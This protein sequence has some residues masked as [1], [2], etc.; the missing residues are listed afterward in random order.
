MKMKG[1]SG[2]VL[3]GMLVINVNLY[4]QDEAADDKRGTGKFKKVKQVIVSASRVEEDASMIA[5][6]IIVITEEDIKKM[7]AHS[8]I[9]VLRTVPDIY[10]AQNG[11][12]GGITTVYLRG[13]PTGQ[14]LVM[15]NGMKVFDP[16]SPDASFDAA[17]ITTD[18][19]ERIEILKGPQSVL[20][21]S[22]AIGG[23]INVITKR[24]KGRF[25][26]NA[27][28][29]MGS[30]RTRQGYIQGSG[31]L[32]AVDISASASGLTSDGMSR[33]QERE[34]EGERDFYKRYN[35]DTRIDWNILTT[36][37]FGA[38]CRYN[39]AWFKTDDGANQDDFNR[40]GDS[41]TITIMTYLD[42]VPVDWWKSTASFAMLRYRRRDQDATDDDDVEDS[43]SFFHGK[44]FKAGWQ[45]SFFIYDID[46][47]TAG[48]E[49][50]HERG[51]ADTNFGSP[52][53]NSK[54]TISVKHNDV[55]SVFINNVFHYWGFYF[56]SGVRIDDHNR[57]GTYNTQRFAGA[58]NFEWDQLDKLPIDW[59][60]FSWA[61]L[62]LKTKLRGAYASGFKSPSI[63]QL[64]SEYGK[65]DLLPE[66][67]WGW[68][69]G[70]EQNIVGNI[71]FGEITYFENNIKDLI[72]YDFGMNAYD[73][74]GSAEMSGYEISFHFI[75]VDWLA[76]KG[77]YSYYEKIR[78][79]VT[80]EWLL[81]RPK[82]KFHISVD[83]TIFKYD[84]YKEQPIW[85]RVN[86]DTIYVG[87]RYDKTGW[88]SRWELLQ[89]F[90]KFDLVCEVGVT[91][92]LSFYYKVQNLTDRFYEEVYG[93][94][95]PERNHTVGF[96]A[97]ISF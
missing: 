39:Y 30:W 95:T 67:S 84:F 94:S 92:F 49:F 48:F 88:P 55:K 9:D 80:K 38:E 37:S 21:G 69:V 19:I 16:M 93:Y 68:E 90:W 32:G 83:W 79:K 47:I 29:S 59:G 91:E 97:S 63:Y 22:N 44:D 71:L 17:H 76:V 53:W 15:V 42:A 64:Y 56:T 52:W 23:V 89:S 81:R 34:N 77:G 43:Y 46:T 35:F 1:L 61:G 18:N 40:Y 6:D 5:N 25:K 72:N 31:S 66:K 51:N 11:A 12:F 57:W 4:A 75:P 10:V 73:N 27:D 26:I 33:A 65:S 2:V 28:G 8:V 78:N 54:S 41:E 45:N 24:G 86:L 3:T 7:K 62:G 20:Y 13:V 96:K 85:A 58:Y 74:E 36:L 60:D 70:I 14:T 50:E 82:E 87:N